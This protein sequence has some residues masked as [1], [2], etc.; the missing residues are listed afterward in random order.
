MNDAI[1]FRDTDYGALCVELG[2]ASDIVTVDSGFMA[3]DADRVRRVLERYARHH[4]VVDESTTRWHVDIDCSPL[5]IVRAVESEMGMHGYSNDA[6]AEN[7][8]LRIKRGAGTC[9]D[10]P[11]PGKVIVHEAI[12]RGIRQHLAVAVAALREHSR[13]T[14][15]SLQYYRRPNAKMAGIVAAPFAV[16][17]IFA[18]RGN[19]DTLRETV[20]DAL[21]PIRDQ[22]VKVSV[23][24]AA[25]Q[26]AIEIGLALAPKLCESF[27]DDAVPS[28]EHSNI[29]GSRVVVFDLSDE[30]TEQE[31]SDIEELARVCT[32][33][34]RI[35]VEEGGRRVVARVPSNFIGN[36]V[37]DRALNE[38]I[39]WLNNVLEPWGCEITD[40]SGLSETLGEPEVK[41]VAPLQE[42]GESALDE[43][44]QVAVTLRDA[45]AAAGS[46]PFRAPH[47]TAS[48]RAMVQE[49]G[50]AAGGVLYLDQL[51]G[52][53]KF[54]IEMVADEVRDRSDVA[55][56]VSP[57]PA[58][59]RG[60]LRWKNFMRILFRGRAVYHESVEHVD[61]NESV[62]EMYDD[63]PP[64]PQ[65]ILRRLSG[66]P[67]AFFDTPQGKS[68]CKKS[69]D[70]VKK[71]EGAEVAKKFEER[72]EIL[73]GTAMESVVDGLVTENIIAQ[74]W[75][76]KNGR[77]AEK[78][79][80][81]LLS[82]MR[83]DNAPW[84]PELNM[85]IPALR[86]RV[87]GEGYGSGQVTPIDQYT[88][89]KLDA[90][91]AAH[92]GRRLVSEAK[93]SKNA[94]TYISKEMRKNLDKGKTQQQSVGASLGAAKS[95]GFD[96]PPKKAESYATPFHR[97]DA[98][99]NARSVNE[100]GGNSGSA[101][102][103]PLLAQLDASGAW[104]LNVGK[105]SLQ[106]AMEFARNTYERAG[107]PELL[108]V[109]LPDLE[110]N[111][112]KLKAKMS[113]ALPIKRIDMP[114]IEPPDIKKFSSDLE[115][116]HVDIFKPYFAGHIG[117]IF[118]WEREG[119]P[120]MF[121]DKEW[122]TLGVKDGD[123][124]DDIVSVKG[125][126]ML[127]VKSLI[128]LQD[129]IWFDKLILT[130]LAFGPPLAGGHVLT[131]AVI[132][133]SKE[134]YILDGHHRFGQAMLRDPGL[135]IKALDVDL[136]IKTLLKVG[137]SYGSALSHHA[138]P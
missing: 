57:P 101:Y 77:S 53:R 119:K 38:R 85:K 92:N 35:H 61:A 129:E 108:N 80:R 110:A 117:N 82:M 118:P 63:L 115:N 79:Y 55:V 114:V 76:F 130:I 90:L 134:G 94:R 20:L 78:F 52:F 133:V 96:I 109:H 67:S 1:M 34:T 122:I 65:A 14:E 99:I 120:R 45:R 41:K 91:A 126:T 106:Q 69:V 24:E 124:R 100:A 51:E 37:A 30:L 102:A 43:A 74:T 83:R 13:V 47:Y 132:I 33:A 4:T 26:T 12:E 3:K 25:D 29:T 112:R 68:M 98:S 17:R 28:F 111:F 105:I 103:K 2:E 9:L 44:A 50:L 123:P 127:S 5:T 72:L 88:F 6:L 84:H 49:V 7:A 23:Q 42:L 138:K 95:K 107:V 136:D 131:N 31:C 93:L 48:N 46:G 62:N 10:L 66:Q 87:T 11:A 81:L 8:I 71:E 128:P 116:G 70:L 21:A 56:M 59:E 89:N 54:G 40:I 64:G 22:L 58:D 16:A 15:P 60:L 73:K 86:V 135:S 104:S 18:E 113:K 125:P 36:Y 32:G 75:E 19:I 121:G 97:S 27:M 39:A 137:R